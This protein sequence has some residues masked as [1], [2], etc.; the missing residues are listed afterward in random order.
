MRM[1]YTELNE[2]INSVN[3]T[4]VVWRVGAGEGLAGWHHWTAFTW[5]P[6]RPRVPA[7]GSRDCTMVE[8][9]GFAGKVI[10]ARP[11]ESIIIDVNNNLKYSKCQSIF[12][13][14]YI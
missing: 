11:I 4:G 3:T 12:S 6:N 8:T 7:A 14:K 5:I 2:L 13:I 10:T 9:V 1:V